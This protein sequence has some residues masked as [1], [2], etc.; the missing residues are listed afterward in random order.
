[1]YTNVKVLSTHHM[2]AICAI[3]Y[4]INMQDA[5]TGRGRAESYE[6]LIKR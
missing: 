6:I 3:Y 1:M 5:P 2:Y 4:E